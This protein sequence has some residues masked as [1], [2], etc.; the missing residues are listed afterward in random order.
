VHLTG[1]RIELMDVVDYHTVD[2][3][4]II[5]DGTSIPAGDNAYDYTIL[6]FVLHHCEDDLAVLREALRVSSKGVL[7]IESV[8]RWEY[9]HRMLCVLDP[10]FN[11]LRSRG[12][13]T[14]Q[15]ESLLFRKSDEWGELF[16]SEGATI[17]SFEER[18]HPI[19]RKAYFLLS[20]GTS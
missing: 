10:L 14:E 20:P 16:R 12:K 1:A 8:F 18:F 5:Y 3:P 15:E 19:H 2:L 6:Y 13:M 7:V 4:F 17:E 11:R 9:E